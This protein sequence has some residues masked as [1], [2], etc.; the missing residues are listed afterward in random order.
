MLLT[1]II[2]GLHNYSVEALNL[3]KIGRIAKSIVVIRIESYPAIF[4]TFYTVR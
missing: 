2:S 4:D 1:K 3:L